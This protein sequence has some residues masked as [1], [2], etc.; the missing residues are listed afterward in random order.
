[1]RTKTITL[2]PAELIIVDEAHHTPARTYQKLIEAYPNAVVIGLTATPCR[3]D[4]RGLGS[5]FKVMIECPRVAKLIEKG[6]LV[7]SRCYAPVTPNLKGV[8]VRAGDYVE[9]QLALRLDDSKLVGDIVT[10]W[11]KFAERRRTVAFAV[12]VAHSLHLRN[13]FVNSGVR[14]E[15]LDGDTPENERNAILARLASGETEVVVNCMVLTEGFDLPDIG[16]IVLA[17]P[18]KKMGLFRQM[19][20][21]GLRPADG[22]KD[23]IILDHSGAVFAHGLPEDHVEWTLRPDRKA[24]SPTHVAR[25]KRKSG[26]LLECSQCSALRLAGEPCPHCGFL[27]QRPARPIPIRDGELGLVTNGRAHSTPADPETRQRW[28]SMLTHIAR[29]RGYKPGW[30]AHKYKEKFGAFP[31]WHANPDPIPPSPEVRSWVRSRQIAYARRP[32]S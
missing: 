8:K 7:R 21:R 9:E 31:N 17:R 25:L 14:T 15:H 19:I 3:G 16:C 5:I 11:H 4:G 27:P 12:N 32:T 30:I 24:Q 26:G 10:N 6:F 29:E 22:K 18:T 2:P 13:E 20:G 1:M 23:S 28:H